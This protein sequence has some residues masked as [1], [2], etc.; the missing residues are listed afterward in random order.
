MSLDPERMNSA[1]RIIQIKARRLCRRS[2]FNSTDRDDIEQQLWIHVLVRAAKFDPARRPWEV[3]LSFILDRRCASI[4]RERL[5]EKRSPCR[6]E[7]SLDDLV[8]DGDGRCVRRDQTTPECSSTP[9]RLRE[10]ANDVA[11]VLAHLSETHRVIA[12]GLVSGTINSIATEQGI[13]RS[14]VGRHVEEIRDAFKDGGLRE[15]L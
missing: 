14:A 1:R 7:C 5:A 6:E 15:Y 4:R 2:G 12:L 13:S 8:L 11:E 9:Q 10:L 3:F